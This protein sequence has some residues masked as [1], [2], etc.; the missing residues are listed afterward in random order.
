MRE[1]Y[2]SVVLDKNPVCE[3]HTAN[4][5][6]SNKIPSLKK[7]IVNKRSLSTKNNTSQGQQS[8]VSAQK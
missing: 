6:P 2:R 4:I 1:Q 5:L 8:A 7:V 3:I